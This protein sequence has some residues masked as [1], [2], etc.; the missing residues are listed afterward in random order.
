MSN[1]ET[2]FAAIQN[3]RKDYL[4]GTPTPEDGQRPLEVFRRNADSEYIKA[5][6]NY[7]NGPHADP[8]AIETATRM[9]MIKTVPSGHRFIQLG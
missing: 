5:R 2:T 9:G 8:S 1:R 6:E 3:A 4:F 7:I